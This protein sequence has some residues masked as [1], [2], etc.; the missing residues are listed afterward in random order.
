MWSEIISKNPLNMKKVKN[1]KKIIVILGP[2]AGGKTG[3]AVKLAQKFNGEIVSADS[4]QVYKG[5]DVGTGKDLKEF[6]IF[7][8]K[9]D[10]PLADNFQFSNKLKKI[11]KKSKIPY[12][13]IDVV[14]PKTEFNLAKYQK[15]ACKAIDNILKRGKT[16]ILVGGS[17]LYLQAVVDGYKLSRAKPDKALRA[18]LEKKNAVQLFALLK[19]IN[20]KFAGKLN[21]SDRKNKRRL[22][23]YIEIIH[24]PSAGGRQTPS[25]KQPPLG[26]DFLV[27]GLTHSREISQKRIYK[28]L[29]E[30]LEKEDMTGEVER[31]RKEGLSWKRLESFGLEYKYVSLYLRKKLTYDE[32]VKKLFIAIKQFAKKQMAWFRRWERQGREIIW[33]KGGGEAERLVKKFIAP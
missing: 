9:A 6:S 30:R 2:T 20:H 1:T 26:Y 21:E 7:Q 17:G 11:E 24:S 33:L 29:I 8:P 3:L 18:K 27:L 19:K 12:H 32:M 5:M 25:A 14:S 4:R 15:L 13:L 22:M 10:P 16:P 23:R 28:R 31:L